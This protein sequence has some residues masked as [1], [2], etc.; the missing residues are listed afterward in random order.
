MLKKLSLPA[1]LLALAGFGLDLG[2]V[3]ALAGAL[4]DL[5]MPRFAPPD[6]ADAALQMETAHAGGV[7][8]KKLPSNPDDDPGAYREPETPRV[9]PGQPDA[10]PRVAPRATPGKRRNQPRART[11]PGDGDR[12]RKP[13]EPHPRRSRPRR[14]DDLVIASGSGFYVNDTGSVVTNHHVIEG[15]KRLFIN[16][17]IPARTVRSDSNIDLALV[18]ADI[19]EATPFLAFRPGPVRLNEDVTVIG[20]PLWGLLDGINVTRGSISSLAGLEG[21]G[22]MV[23][24]TAP[25]QSGNSGGPVLDAAGR[26]VGVVQSKLDAVKLIEELGEIAQNINFAIDARLAQEFLTGAGAEFTLSAEAVRLS[27]PDLADQARQATVL[28]ECMGN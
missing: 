17:D 1:L 8:P 18:Q 20:F 2:P 11:E 21:D 14:D 6:G 26:V 23:Q 5:A 27:P 28:I 22:R 13:R 10:E 24:I 15:C 19:T 12:A 7:P 16:G 25:V 9:T 4:R 3:P